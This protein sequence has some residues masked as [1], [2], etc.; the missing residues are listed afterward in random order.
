M[1]VLPTYARRAIAIAT[2]KALQAALKVALRTIPRDHHA[3]SQFLHKAL[4]IAYRAPSRAF[5]SATL[6]VELPVSTIVM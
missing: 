5:S 3:G 1:T 6:P 2:Y 4:A